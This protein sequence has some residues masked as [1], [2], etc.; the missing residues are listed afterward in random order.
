MDLDEHI[1]VADAGFRNVLHPDAGF[2]AC[3]DECFHNCPLNDAELAPG[4]AE[5][6]NNFDRAVPWCARRSSACECALC[7]AVPPERQRPP[8]RHR[9][10]APFRQLN[11]QGSFAQHD[12]NDG[13]LAR[14]QIES[15]ALHVRAEVRV[16]WRADVRAARA[17]SP[18]RSSTFRWRPPPAARCCW[19]RD[20]GAS[21]GAARRRSPCGR[22]RSRRWR[23]PRP[24]RRSR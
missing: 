17:N 18:S 1:V 11:G 23:R 24:C 10:P 22:R 21:A 12:G 14:Q 9:R 3:F 5:G 13:M 19:K 4:A 20:R 15:Q 7:R 2:R 8:H 6:L 16:R